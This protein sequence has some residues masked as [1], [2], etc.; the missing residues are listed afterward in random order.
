MAAPVSPAPVLAA[1]G[2]IAAASLALGLALFL[3]QERSL[4]F[5]L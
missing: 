3:R 4:V 2:L 5:R 1:A